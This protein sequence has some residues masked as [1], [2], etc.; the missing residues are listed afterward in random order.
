ME[1]WIRIW[2]GSWIRIQRPLCLNMASIR[3]RAACYMRESAWN[4]VKHCNARSLRAVWRSREPT[5]NSDRGSSESGFSA[6]VEHPNDNSQ[7]QCENLPKGFQLV[8]ASASRNSVGAAV[9]RVE[10]LLSSSTKKALLSIGYI[11]S[12]TLQV[13]GNPK[14]TVIVTYAPTNVS[15]EEEVKDYYLLPSIEWLDT[16]CES[17]KSGSSLF[18]YFLLF[19]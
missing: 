1:P 15:D 2:C 6:H 4:P 16:F 19:F 11:S 9:G 18:F 12:R 13:S 5:Q 14:T 3:I 7:L 17:F 10:I 8:T